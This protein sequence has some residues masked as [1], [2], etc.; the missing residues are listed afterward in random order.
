MPWQ[1]SEPSVHRVST[2][3]HT[4]EHAHPRAVTLRNCSVWVCKFDRDRG[5]SGH[6]ALAAEQTERLHLCARTHTRSHARRFA[7]DT[8][9]TG[10]T[11]WKDRCS[12]LKT[13]TEP[14]ADLVHKKTWLPLSW[15][16][17][18]FTF[19][20]WVCLTSTKMCRLSLRPLKDPL[21]PPAKTVLYLLRRVKVLSDCL[22]F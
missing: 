20:A 19:L 5:D 17:F 6:L 14:R 21:P 9:H 13:H 1:R 8:L 11:R 4:H 10:R 15:P 7:E 3:T 18:F 16:L 12:Q 22:C 2:H